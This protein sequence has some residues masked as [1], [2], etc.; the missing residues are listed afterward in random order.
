MAVYKIIRIYEVPAENQTQALERMMKALVLGVE[1]DFHT[2]DYVKK[3]ED[4]RGK[5]TK[6]SLLPPRGW[7]AL[8]LDQLGVNKVSKR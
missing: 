6:I 3:P 5:G 1:K 2:V 4:E 8:V 7:V